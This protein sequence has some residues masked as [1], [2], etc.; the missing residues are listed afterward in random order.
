D[1]KKEI[2]RFR[3]TASAPLG[4]GRK[5]GKNSFVSSVLGTVQTFYEDVV[6]GLRPWTP[7]APQLPGGG[8]SAAEEAGIDIRT[9]LSELNG[10]QQSGQ[11]GRQGVF[12]PPSGPPEKPTWLSD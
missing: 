5:V 10:R 4:G 1:P 7:K 8:R 11:D 2:R 6:Q 3:L 12:A 9:P